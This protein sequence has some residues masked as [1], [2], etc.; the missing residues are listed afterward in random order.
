MSRVVVAAAYGGPEVLALVEEEPG[1]PGP[2]EVLIEVRAAGVNPADWKTYTGAWGSDPARLPL[3]L[4][5]EAAGVVTAVGPDV[6][7]F[8]PGD[9]VIAHPVQ[10]AYADHLVVPAEDLVPKPAGLDW[11]RAGGLM[12]AGTTAVNAV[13]AA[14]V[15]A[16]DTVLV[17]GASG[18]VGAMVTQLAHHRGA[19]VIG[20]ASPANHE[21][22]VDLGAAPLAHGPGLVERVRALA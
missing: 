4:G 2:G 21:Y 18:G 12:L 1:V 9:E 16:G 6:E 8:S 7:A 19:R 20:T 11:A 5:F 10:G 3:R 13:A 14:A 17:H 15:G 22:L